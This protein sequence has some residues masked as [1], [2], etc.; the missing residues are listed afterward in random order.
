MVQEGKIQVLG[1]EFMKEL[2]DR[3][4]DF[5]EALESCKSRAHYERGKWEEFMIQDGLLFR[6]N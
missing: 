2:Y 3:D 6:N 5:Q 1:F 4:P